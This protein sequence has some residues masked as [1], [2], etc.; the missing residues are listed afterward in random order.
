MRPYERD[1]GRWKYKPEADRNRSNKVTKL[2]KLVT[3][4]ANR[5]RKKAYRQQ[6]K[7]ELKDEID[8]LS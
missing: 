7:K 2:E 8:N 4:N 3:K 6:L 5:S 1:P